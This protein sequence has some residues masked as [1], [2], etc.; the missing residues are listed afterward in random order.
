ML[1]NGIAE[2]FDGRL[3]PPDKLI[4]DCGWACRMKF[5]SQGYQDRPRMRLVPRGY[6]QQMH[7]DFK[8][9]GITSPVCKHLSLML[10]MVLVANFRLL[11]RIVDITKA[12]LYGA[13][14]ELVFMKVP[15]GFT[16]LLTYLQ[17][18]YYYK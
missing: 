5:D 11:T 18:F 12:F 9:H 10:L 2:E 4:M 6:Q 1:Q 7:S 3:C 15:D 14:N 8:E 17:R 13:C 16:Y